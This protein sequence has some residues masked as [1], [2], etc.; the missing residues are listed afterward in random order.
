MHMVNWFAR[1]ILWKLRH[2]ARAEAAKTS[3]HRLF[4]KKKINRRL[5]WYLRTEKNTAEIRLKRFSAGL[6][7]DMF[8]KK[9]S[10][11]S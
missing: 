2:F 7:Q 6:L 3:Q 10:S 8:P 4:L 11:N 5:P 9:S 1:E